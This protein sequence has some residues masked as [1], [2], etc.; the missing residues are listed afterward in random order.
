M[1]SESNYLTPLFD[2]D[3]KYTDCE[4]CNGTG[5]HYYINKSGQCEKEDCFEC[6][7][8]GQLEIEN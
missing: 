8:S 5:A 6:N 2:K 1:E 7:G 4:D 3:K